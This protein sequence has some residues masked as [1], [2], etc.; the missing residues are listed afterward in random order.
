VACLNVRSVDIKLTTCY[1]WLRD[2][3][4]AVFRWSL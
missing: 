4:T 3:K 2:D 1:L